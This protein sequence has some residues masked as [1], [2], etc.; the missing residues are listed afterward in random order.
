MRPADYPAAVAEGVEALA[1]RDRLLARLVA[2]HG[3]CTL[4]PRWRRTPY[5][6]LVRAVMYQQLHGKAAAT[7]F[8]R[9]LALFPD[10]R[11]PVPERVAGA[12]DDLLRS[13][14]LSRQ[15]ATYV[16][17]IAEGAL[18]GIVPL[19]RSA[20]TA[21]DDE[22]IVQRLTGIRGIGRW[23]VEMMLI[24][25]LGRLDVFPVHDFGVRAGYLRAA[26]RADITPASLGVVA[27]RWRPYRSLAAWYLWR[28]AEAV[29]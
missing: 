6:A 23:T 9:F 7:I 24:F 21:L 10:E 17:A 25:T 20:L 8:A 12:D 19:K 4:A 29:D 13:A 3:A 11:F 5:E 18:A 22:A 27:E 28:A 15:K 2:R 14:G 26:R 1:K 16:R